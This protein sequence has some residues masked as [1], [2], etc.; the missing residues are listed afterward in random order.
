MK[1]RED[2]E[3]TWRAEHGLKNLCA[4]LVELVV[5][6]EACNARAC[7]LFLGGLLLT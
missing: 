4:L 2:E 3:G 1:K 5:L 7:F 6:H